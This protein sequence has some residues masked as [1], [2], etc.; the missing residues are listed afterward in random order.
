VAYTGKPEMPQLSSKSLEASVHDYAGEIPKTLA[1]RLFSIPSRSST[2]HS[3]PCSEKANA[4]VMK[5]DRP[6]KP[7]LF[8][9]AR[10]MNKA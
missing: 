9:F 8:E 6:A 10:L 2:G 4:S 7:L 3:P 5:A 1:D